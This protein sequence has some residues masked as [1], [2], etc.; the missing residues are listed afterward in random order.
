M[1]TYKGTGDYSKALE[2]CLELKNLLQFP[3]YSANNSD[4]PYDFMVYNN[5]AS[6]YQDMKQTDSS[7]HYR[8]MAFSLSMKAEDPGLLALSTISL[9]DFYLT[10]NQLDSS[11]L[12]NRL[13]VHY[14]QLVGRYD[15]VREAYLG[16]AGVFE[17]QKK[18]DSAFSYAR[19]AFS[20]NK[21]ANDSTGMGGSAL[22]LSK[23]FAQANRY[24]SAYHYLSAYQAINAN[25]VS[26]EKINKVQSLGFNELIRQNELAQ[27]HKEAI[28]QY[29]TRLKVYSLI[30]GLSLL[31]LITFILF[32]NNRQKQ[33]AN[34]VLENTLSNLRSTQAQLVQ[35][36]KMAGLGELTAGIAHE[37]QNPLNFVNNFSEISNELID[38]MKEELSKGNVKE[39]KIIAG[40]IKQNLEKINHHGKRADSIV[41]GMLQ[42]SRSSTGQKEPADINALCDEY[43][44]LAFH[45]LRA[46][47]K[48]FQANF[49]TILD[50]SINKVNI[51]PQDIGRVLLNLINNAFY[52]VQ[53]KAKTAGEGYSPTVTVSTQK[54]N[55]QLIIAVAD[56]GTGIPQQLID[57]IFQP[58]FTTKPT[59]SGTGLGLSLAYDIIKAHGGK[60]NVTTKEGEGTQFIIQLP[61]H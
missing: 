8:Q 15:I 45:G 48:S 46:R 4:S 25:L 49:K 59:G 16:L 14:G 39:A 50:H 43:L 38:E 10:N 55:G 35:S 18:T 28:Q 51:V 60:L 53:E 29:Q 40:D 41:K 17:H 42:H 22:M 20:K 27:E 5:L 7:Q 13:A 34:V 58:F 33:K 37:I 12:Y 36:E 26:R 9:G 30:A 11:L 1:W 3:F 23:L 61:N 2:I 47:D 56:N 19:L 31:V 44:R 57:K 32:R 21:V 6:C 52:A 54:E 24:D